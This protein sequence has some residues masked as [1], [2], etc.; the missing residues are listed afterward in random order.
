MADDRYPASSFV[1]PDVRIGTA[2]R[3]FNL[4]GRDGK[5]AFL[6]GIAAVKFVDGEPVQGKAG[7]FECWF[8]PYQPMSKRSWRLSGTPEPE[9]FFGHTPAELYANG[10][11]TV[12]A[13]H[14]FIAFIGNARC[15]AF[16][17]DMTSWREALNNLPRDEGFR[18]KGMNRVSLNGLFKTMERRGI[19][20]EAIQRR[21]KDHDELYEYARIIGLD[22][23]LKV[24]TNRKTLADEAELVGRL[25]FGASDFMQAEDERLGVKPTREWLA[26]YKR[27]NVR[28]LKLTLD[29][30]IYLRTDYRERQI[31]RSLGAHWDRDLKSWYINIWQDP[32]PFREWLAP[33]DFSDLVELARRRTAPRR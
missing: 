24:M 30:R 14:R 13:L 11:R 15:I 28:D 20:T 32:M 7:R 25:W 1:P 5:S 6:C 3:T 19:R 18:L 21:L 2:F 29:T 9:P 23:P 33:G 16:D 12:D 26:S 8:F 22:T 4:E 31:V 10:I 17:R 27:L